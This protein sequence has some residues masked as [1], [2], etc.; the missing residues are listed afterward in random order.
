M[1]RCNG[2]VSGFPR[3]L[4]P[5]LLRSISRWEEERGNMG[6]SSFTE[7]SFFRSKCGLEKGDRPQ[8]KNFFLRQQIK[9]GSPPLPFSNRINVRKFPAP[10][11]QTFS[12]ELSLKRVFTWAPQGSSFSVVESL[13]SSSG[14]NFFSFGGKKKL[15][16]N[17]T[18]RKRRQKQS[19][20]V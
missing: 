19:S 13:T 6:V 4:I 2:N 7:R 15:G 3:R 5:F 11:P 8:Q 10:P 16:K 9:T 12:P 14:F 1:C 20:F 18:R 17:L